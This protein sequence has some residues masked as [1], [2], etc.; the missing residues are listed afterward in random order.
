MVISAMEKNKTKTEDRECLGEGEG[1]HAILN[2]VVR[3]YHSKK[4]YLRKQLKE[5]N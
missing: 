3:K 2:R 1:I 4:Q 5:M